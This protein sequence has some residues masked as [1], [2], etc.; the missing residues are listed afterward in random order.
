LKRTSAILA[1]AGAALLLASPVLSLL[2]G[3]RVMPSYLADWLFWSS[4]PLG[5]LPVVMLLDLAGPGPGFG[6]EPALRR[7]LLL[8]PGA[9]LLLIP[10]LVRPGVLFGWAMGHGFTTPFGHAWMNHGAFIVRSV[11]YFALWIILAL[12]FRKPPAPGAV[13]RRQGIAAIGLFAYALTATLAAV[14]WAMTVEPNWSSPEFGMLLISTEAAIAVSAALLLAGTASRQA[15][16]EE[17]AAFLLA[18]AAVW[19][20]L[21]FIQYLVIWSADKPS[22]IAWYLHR[23]GSGSE[24]VVW[25][26]F[27]GGFIIPFFTLLSPRLRRHPVTLPANAILMLCVQALGTLWLI[28]PSLRQRFMISAMDVLEL[29]GLGGVM[30]GACLWPMPVAKAAR[31]G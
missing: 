22:D 19:V 8:M 21:Q 12:I 7:Q 24:V 2:T 30:L 10:I 9:A 15:A 16:R 20:F 13:A 25:F 27:I 18:A 5:A 6:L 23:A 29:A 3:A 4:L 28:T 1:L 14:D 26:G 17:A 31:H 11:V